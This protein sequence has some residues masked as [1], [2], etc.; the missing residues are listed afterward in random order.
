MRNFST[1]RF[2]FLFFLLVGWLVGWW[3]GSCSGLCRD[4]RERSK[5]TIRGYI[6]T[7]R[8]KVCSDVGLDNAEEFLHCMNAR[9][10]ASTR[11]DSLERGRRYPWAVVA[12]RSAIAGEIDD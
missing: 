6:P 9:L 1:V 8:E 12:R 4:L 2:F 11:E 5:R 3:V 7:R 10:D